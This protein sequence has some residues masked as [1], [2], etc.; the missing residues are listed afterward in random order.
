MKD[1]YYI[2]Y[3]VKYIDEID[4]T[5]KCVNEGIVAA[6][7]FQDAVE[8]LQLYYGK[9]I[10]SYTFEELNDDD[11]GV[12]D[13]QDFENFFKEKLNNLKTQEEKDET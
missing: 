12:I 5:T 3:R 8:K 13:F 7:D 1:I 9:G 2:Y 11:I 10:Y 4:Y 6:T